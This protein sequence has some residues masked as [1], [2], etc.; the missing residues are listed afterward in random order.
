MALYLYLRLKS[1]VFSLVLS[2]HLSYV[3][4]AEAYSSTEEAK[5]IAVIYSQAVP[6]TCN[7]T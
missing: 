7:E 1:T 3:E 5:T 6:F 2:L 4:Q